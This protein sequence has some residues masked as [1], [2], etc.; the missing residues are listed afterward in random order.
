MP[1][2]PFPTLPFGSSQASRRRGIAFLLLSAT[3]FAVVALRD[4]IASNP[5]FHPH[6]YCYLWDPGLVWMHVGADLLIGVAYM[7]IP[8]ALL[9]IVRRA[10][11]GLPFSGVL[12][13]FGTF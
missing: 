4:V 10:E 12:V 11:G 6:G 9:T 8:I 7:T 3:A 5:L 2:Q 13:A 1:N